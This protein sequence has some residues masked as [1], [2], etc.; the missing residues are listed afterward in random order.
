MSEPVWVMQQVVIS[1]H[2][3]SLAD[4][5]GPSG[6][7]DLGLLESALARPK[8]LFAYSEAEP[9]LAQMAAAYAFGINANHAF[10]DGN[11]R[12]ALIVSLAFLR[13]NGLELTAEKGDRYLMFY[14]LAAGTISE[15]AIAEWFALKTA[16]L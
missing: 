10:V 8:N 4:H 6:I 16:A 12:T 11:K 14:G 5:G 7:R 13:L 15:D 3:E 1:A 2:E 9:T